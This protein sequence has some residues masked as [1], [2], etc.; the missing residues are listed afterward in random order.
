MYSK[1]SNLEQFKK[2][3]CPKQFN[4]L[5]SICIKVQNNY[6]PVISSQLPNKTTNTY[7]LAL[8]KVTK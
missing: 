1:L 2:A 5:F 4:Q 7:I 8:N 3:N 6:V